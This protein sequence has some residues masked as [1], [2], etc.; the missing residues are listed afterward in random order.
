MA[1]NEISQMRTDKSFLA[2]SY[3]GLANILLDKEQGFFDLERGMK[4]AELSAELKKEIGKG[5]CTV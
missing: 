5:V 1:V 3:A 4:L 2:D